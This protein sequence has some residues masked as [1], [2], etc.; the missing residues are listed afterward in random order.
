MGI[1]GGATTGTGTGLTSITENSVAVDYIVKE[2][3]IPLLPWHTRPLLMVLSRAW[4]NALDVIV[5]QGRNILDAIG[6]R[7]ARATRFMQP[8][9]CRVAVQYCHR[10]RRRYSELLY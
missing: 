2:E 10:P 8:L 3:I 7:I 4:R 9:K 5:V 6:E 1:L